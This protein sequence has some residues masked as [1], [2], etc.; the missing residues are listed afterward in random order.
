MHVR[1][2]V[3]ARPAAPNLYVAPG[4]QGGRTSPW[5]VGVEPTA[6]PAAAAQAH[7]ARPARPCPRQLGLHNAD[8]SHPIRSARPLTSR[9]GL[10][11][12]TA[13]TL[14]PRPACRAA[15]PGVN[16]HH[17][18]T[19]TFN[20]CV[21]PACV[22][23]TCAC[24]RRAGRPD[25]SLGGGSGADGEAGSGGPGRRSAGRLVDAAGASLGMPGAVRLSHEG[26][27]LEV[28]GD[29]RAR[30]ARSGLR[31][32]VLNPKTLQTYKPKNLKTKNLKTE[33]NP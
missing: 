13:P 28:R 27:G 20:L 32:L 30:L 8:P 25:L 33:R 29:L 15:G 18:N 12:L 17:V 7:Q 11:P 10:A 5:T 3:C 22:R 6:R 24:A 2:H 31:V 19:R 21:R 1:I 4:V 14:P 9:S 23:P 16:T 26:T